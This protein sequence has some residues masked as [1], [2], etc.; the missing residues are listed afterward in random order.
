MDKRRT[1]R[2][3]EAVREELSQILG[4]EMEDPRLR[5]ITVA[6]V[7]VTP[8]GRQARV[9][10]ALW[11]SEDEKK[12]TLSALNHA[13]N[14]LRHELAGRLQLRH[15]PELLFSADTGM[16]AATRVETLL[17]RVRKNRRAQEKLPDS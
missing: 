16:E 3:S 11:G 2:V 14:H 8:D 12:Q 13:R 9:H 6:E 1:A 5:G 15:V 17:E 7:S 4:F 10:V